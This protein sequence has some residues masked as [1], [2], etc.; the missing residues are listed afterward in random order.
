[1]RDH[2][3]ATLDRLVQT[4]PSL[5]LITGDL[6]FG[7]LDDFA[8]DHPGSFLNAGV[9]E[10]NMTMV[11]AGCALAG[12]TVFT[13]SIANFPTLRCLEM[14]RNDVCYHDLP[15]VAV[16]IGGGYSYGALGMSHH[17]TEDLAI[18]RALPKMTVVAPCDLYEVER[19]TQ[20][21]VEANA[22]GYLRIDKSKVTR[23]ESLD[24]GFELGRAR[25]L[26]AGQDV[27]IIGCGGVLAVA[28]DAAEEL[29]DELSAQVLSM[30]TVSDIDLDAVR[31]AATE[32]AGIVVI[33]EH[34][35]NGGLGS[36]VLEAV[37]DLGLGGTPIRR[38][39][40]DPNTWADV[41]SQHYLRGLAGLTAPA[42]CN[43]ARQVAGSAER[44][45]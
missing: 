42:V 32:T 20:A 19:A 1:M 13:Y 38:L 44:N 31:T 22:P 43:A 3:I 28:L 5:L 16:A 34:V 15:V 37:S 12:R 39:G 35:R 36:A 18:L 2:F 25:V 29:A 30:H 6:G 10:Q 27:T 33:E 9:A 45:P 24:T 40:L 17:A 41:G 11:A 8:K 23:T 14:L 7:V 21:L 26:R 4:D